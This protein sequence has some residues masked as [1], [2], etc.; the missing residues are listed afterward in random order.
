MF[1]ELI[2]KTDVFITNL[3]M[4][5][6]SRF[7]IE[8]EALRNVN[9]GLITIWHTGMGS[10]G[11]Y[12]G[13]KVFG[14]QL[15]AMAGVDMASGFKG[16]PPAWVSTSLFDF[17]STMYMVSGILGAL[18]KRRRTGKGM[19]IEISLFEAARAYAAADNRETV[20]MNDI[21]IVAPMALRLRSSKF[22]TK[23]F[24]EHDKEEKTLQST[25]DKFIPQS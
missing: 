6:L 2:K 16:G 23:Y 11:P 25:M 12:A 3:W 15:Q 13:Y 4:E 17:H 21:R 14:G 24:D 20:S 1:N 18:E 10:E 19:S 9:P 7:G 8:F 22:I 5:A